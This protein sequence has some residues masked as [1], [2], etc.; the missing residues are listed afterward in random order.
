MK[1]VFTIFLAFVVSLSAMGIHVTLHKCGGKT[2]YMVF[3]V[4]YKKQCKCKHSNEKRK[5]CCDKKHLLIKTIDNVYTSF[6]K[7]NSVQN[8]SLQTFLIPSTLQIPSAFYSSYSSSSSSHSPPHSGISL[9]ALQCAF[10]I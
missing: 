1:K 4:E 8:V 10:R 2:S 6:T 5:S 3:G 9:L 7:I